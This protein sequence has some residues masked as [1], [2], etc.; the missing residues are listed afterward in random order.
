MSQTED[1]EL[2]YIEKLQEKCAEL[3]QELALKS[4]LDDQMGELL[5]TSTSLEKENR[6]LK[7]ELRQVQ[8]QVMETRR[9]LD[10][11]RHYD[12][13]VERWIGGV[14]NELGQMEYKASLSHQ[15]IEESVVTIE[16]LKAKIVHLEEELDNERGIGTSNGHVETATVGVQARAVSLLSFLEG[17]FSRKT[18]SEKGN[19]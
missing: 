7:E 19:I 9:M 17:I 4:E 5:S 10:K 18:N 6:A 11:R 2:Q 12:S 1:V 16:A 3:R 15:D 8:S 13:E 14:K